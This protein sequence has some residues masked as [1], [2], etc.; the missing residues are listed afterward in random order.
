MIP[1]NAVAEIVTDKA[2]VA[3]EAQDEGFIAALLHEAG[4]DDIAVGT[5]IAVVVSDADDV[6]AFSNFTLADATGGAA[7][8]ATPAPPAAPVAPVAPA[9]QTIAPPP[10]APPAAVP[11]P[12]KQA[13]TAAE[14]QLAAEPATEQTSWRRQVRKASP[15][16]ASMLEEQLA[17]EEQFGFTG[18]EPLERAAQDE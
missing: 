11:A 4:P 5:P 10:S 1:G 9:A 8:E 15:L 13:P 6:A 17:Y 12:P 14:I 2:S 16:A 3:F 7:N 18:M